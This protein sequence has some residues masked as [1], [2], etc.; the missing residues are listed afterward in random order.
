MQRVLRSMMV[1]MINVPGGNGNDR[2][3]AVSVSYMCSFS[4]AV[5]GSMRYLAMMVRC[6]AALMQAKT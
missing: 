5:R 3:A 6:S 4:S 1:P 2:G